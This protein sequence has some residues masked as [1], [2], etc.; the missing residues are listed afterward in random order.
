MSNMKTKLGVI[1]YAKYEQPMFTDHSNK[2]WVFF[3]EDNL[4]PLYLDDLFISSSIHGAIVT[5]TA[6]MIYGEGLDSDSKDENVKQWLQLTG[7]FRHDSLKRA[8]FDLKLYG[9]AYLNVIWSQDRSSISEVHHVPASTIR[10]G[11]ADDNDDIKIFYHSTNWI[12]SNQSTFKPNPIPAFDVNDR[13]AASQ[14]VHIKSYSPVSFFYGMP[15]YKG[16]TAYCELDKSIAEFHLSNIKTGL[17]PSMAISF[18]SGIPTDDERRD[19][20]RLIYDKFGGASNAGKILMTFNDGQDS[21]PTIE[22]FNLPNPHDTYDFLAKQVFQEILSG[23]RVTSPLLF[24]L[25]S[26]GGGFGSNADEMRDAY[27]LYSKTVVEPFQHTLLHGIKPILSANSIVLDVY[28]KDLV[29]ASFIVQKEEEEKKKI[30][31]KQPV[32]INDTQ[33]SIW[34]NHLADK[35]APLPKEFRLLKEEAIT[36]T[37]DD[38]RLHSMHKFGLE[39]YSNYDLVSDWGDVVSPQG[40]L[41]AVRYQYFKATSQQPKGNSRD[42]CVEMMDLSDA[43]VQY[44]YEDIGNMSSDGVNGQFAAAG[45]STYDIFEWAG[46]KNCYHGFKRLIYVYVPDGLPDTTDGL[47]ED[48]DAVMRR[49]GNNPYIVQKGEEAIAPIDKQ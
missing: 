17:F 29:P 31:S 21:A 11:K 6:D 18:N 13:T 20:E 36:D 37:S 7:M 48:W 10:C 42:F 5:G 19:L 4:Y 41:F 15:D 16:A 45:Q 35:N 9:N 40:N 38:K 47:Y 2:D 25:R 12:E 27:D 46:G 34:L 44:R 14:I 30:F 24:G 8:A 32:R 39:D 28:F 22:P 23:H 49:V 26:E 33:G 43:G 1:D 3:G